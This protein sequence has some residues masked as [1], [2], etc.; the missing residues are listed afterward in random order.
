MTD[1]PY[2]YDVAA[3]FTRADLAVVRE[4]MNGLRDRGLRIWFNEHLMPGG[5]LEPMITS[6][7]LQSRVLLVFFSEN[8]HVSN[9]TVTEKQALRFRDPANKD[10]QFVPIRL[11]STPLPQSYRHLEHINWQP[12]KQK[13]LID[14]LSIV[15]G[16]LP[17]KN[18]M[19]GVSVPRN[20]YKRR[21]FLDSKSRVSVIE[22]ANEALSSVYGTVD[23]EIYVIGISAEL[24]VK[25]KLVG[26]AGKIV[27]LSRN[28][29]CNMLL[30]TSVDRTV[31]L[32]DLRTGLSV[33]TFFANSATVPNAVFAGSSIVTS[34]SEDA[35]LIWDSPLETEVPRELRGHKRGVNSLCA[36]GSTVVSAGN[37]GTIRVWDVR[38]GQCLRVL[39]GHTGPVRSLTVN[40]SGSLLLSGSDDCTIRLWNLRSGLAL[41]T[42]DAHTD[43]VRKL[44][45][46]PDGNLFASGGGDRTL[47][48]WEQTTGKLLRVFDGNENDATGIA[49]IG[50]EFLAGDGS[51]VY[52][53]SLPAISSAESK[54]ST[55]TSTGQVSQQIQY[56]NAKVLLVGDSGAGK[57]GIS[58]RL[59]YE[60]YEPSAASTVGAWA[61]QW[62]LP[63]QRGSE[64]DREIWLWDFGGQADQRL[65]HQLY[66]DDT[67]LAVL[68]FD[69]QKSNVF[70]AL[71]QWDRDLTRATGNQF[72]KL[73]VAGR[74]DA[75]P[76]RASRQDIDAYVKEHGFQGYIET[77]ALTNLGCSELRQAI[78]DNID[79]SR[80]PWRSS[81][82]LFKRLKEEIVKLK[83][84]G[85]I[86]MRFN[87]LRDSLRLRLPPNEINFADAELKAVLSLLAGPGVIVELEFGAWVLLQPELINAYSQAVI[88]TM[89]DD[90]SELGC[91]S[92]QRVLNGDLVYG[93]FTRITAE[94]ERFVL[95]EMHRKLLQRGICARE[96]TEKDVLL[97]FPSYYKRNRPELIG[98]PA[99]LV[100]YRFDGVV[101][102]VYSTLVVRLDHTHEFARAQ[103]WQDAA[104]FTTKGGAKIGIKLSRNSQ[105]A[106]A[107]IEI[108]TERDTLLAEKIIFVKYVHDHLVQRAT[109]VKRR[110]HYICPECSSPIADLDAAERRRELGRNDIGCQICDSRVALF[111][112]L[113]HLYMSAEIQ[114]KVRRLEGVAN[115]ELDN[116]SKERAL[117]GEVISLVALANQISR[118]K[119]V[120][121]HGIDMEI[122]FK[123]DDRRATGKLL[124]LQLKSGD[125]YL[126][127]LV[128]GKE[129][130]SLKNDRHA[131]YWAEQIAPVMLVIRS[132]AGEIRWMEIRGYLREQ[133]RKKKT[134]RQ[135]EFRGTKMDI[136]S[137]L[138]WREMLLKEK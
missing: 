127:T 68:V 73:L 45:W 23:G 42:F 110:R 109:N 43:S 26:H 104:E 39:E 66:M 106:A 12:D 6:A 134:V 83:D 96:L 55:S 69:A 64:G 44:T 133:L 67:A 130:F 57:T 118:E 88:A 19:Q 107:A 80:I 5:N 9:W 94:D 14:R 27:D 103:L 85:R 137:I 56:T 90:P 47:R 135:I 111:D 75:S 58:K 60:H 62:S 124:F 46:H 97:V 91:V 40:P 17:Q 2:R 138:T 112:D 99:V 89:R 61:T 30:S 25:L 105:S 81:P 72:S 125:S 54:P 16:P 63:T 98:H 79:W 20:L 87:E 123:N 32:W 48:L 120:S 36:Y 13:E 65:I 108:Y 52:A 8:A 51:N 50:T 102:E 76:V 126:R 31:R 74:I 86:L 115:E 136:D 1:K 117:V 119:T 11:D 53:W 21:T 10:L 35:L 28:D 34:T 38:T 92:E 71:S 100:S 128:D 113:E 82:V 95:L 7:L 116:E 22:L 49:I 101:D 33:R 18:G 84:E 93:G 78:I 131:K 37:D 15:C 3:S 122:E 129:V 114:R 4:I 41:N 70:E 121:D 29:E 24:D 59:A 77:S 132:S